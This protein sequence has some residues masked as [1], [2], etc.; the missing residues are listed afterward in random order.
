MTRRL[1][2]I[3]SD[4]YPAYV[5]WELTLLC[6]Q[7]CSHCGSRAFRKRPNELNL[8]QALEVVADLKSLGTEEVILIGGEAYLHENFLEIA[9]A[10]VQS[11]IAVGMTTGGQGISSVRAQA[12]KDIGIKRVSV[13]IDGM[14][15]T[16]D[17]VRLKRNS[18]NKAINALDNLREAGLRLAVN[19]TINS[20]NKHELED[21]Y[22][23][24]K[25]LMVKAWQLQIMAPLG[26]AADRPFLLIE[27]HD[28]LTIMPTIAK[29]KRQAFT[30]DM[31]IMPGNNLGYFGPEEALLR[32]TV[33]DGS[34]CFMGCQAGRFIMGIESD[35]TVK[36]CPSLQ[37][38]YYSAGNVKNERL[39]TLWKRSLSL[40]ELRDDKAK[41]LWGFCA[42]CEYKDT[43][44]AGCTFT[45]HA[46]FGRAGNNPYCHYRARH[47]A[48]RGL[49]E[50]LKMVKA[51]EGK[52][53]D[54]GLF[55]IEVVNIA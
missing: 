45:S 37:T 36:G 12:I 32:S 42:T 50:E 3:E 41:K 10:L 18:F 24:L 9:Q 33:K 52:P 20:L 2:I 46:L 30:D 39:A 55:E 44:K 40:Q 4:P 6:D 48:N 38:S 35:G 13:S 25:S 5:V 54:H 47:F 29:L 16:H 49:K 23:L 8:A 11:G 27:P 19:T 51:P 1:N 28:L 31:L 7:R 14:E 15:R 17:R 43:C 21:L 22:H 34:D 26:R 53:F